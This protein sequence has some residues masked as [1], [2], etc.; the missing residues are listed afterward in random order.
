[1]HGGCLPNVCS[2]LCLF[3]RLNSERESEESDRTNHYLAIQ[4]REG[5]TAATWAR[6]LLDAL[7]PKMI[8][9]FLPI[10]QRSLTFHRRLS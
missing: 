2:G 6:D 1:M 10:L 9:K 5:S 7:Q 3:S 4:N 8:G